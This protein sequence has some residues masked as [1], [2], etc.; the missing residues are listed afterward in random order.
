M[1]EGIF[2]GLFNNIKIAYVINFI[3]SQGTYFSIYMYFIILLLLT[4]IIILFLVNFQML[5]L[6]R[7]IHI[8]SV[9]ED[10]F[11]SNLIKKYKES[12]ERQYDII[13]TQSYIESYFANYSKIKFY[14]IYLIENSGFLF[15]LMGI[16][17]AFSVM[18][19]A[20]VS[21]DF[22]GLTGFQ[23]LYTRLED[24]I[25]TFKPALFFLIVGII[26]AIIIN[27]FTKIFNI[28]SRFKKIKFR[29][30]NYLENNLK[31]KYNKEIKQL[32]L[33]EKLIESINSNFISLED[34]IEDSINDSFSEI[35][36]TIAKYINSNTSNNSITEKKTNQIASTKEDKY[37]N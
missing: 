25:Y 35:N 14:L 4:E 24:V 36:E 34:V 8:D 27:I 10:T 28:N 1:K 18:L 22:D 31:Y 32:R 29:L 6:E 9:K 23:G 15:L 20:I 17:G 7:K 5:K 37:K 11:L 13:N 16:L 30:E 21:I 26:A 19:S 2:M 33:F 12:L 3:H